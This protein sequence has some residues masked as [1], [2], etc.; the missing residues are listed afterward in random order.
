MKKSMIQMLAISALAVM[1]FVVGCSDSEMA[2]AAN[3]MKSAK[4]ALSKSV[5][6]ANKAV[7][8]TKEL[9]NLGDAI[10][11][12]SVTASMDQ[13]KQLG[14][15]TLEMVESSVELQQATQELSK[16]ASETVTQLQ[17]S[18]VGKAAKE[19]AKQIDSADLNQA[20]DGLKQSMGELNKHT[21]TLSKGVEGLKSLKSLW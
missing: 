8:V 6:A 17:N 16:K 20:V 19:L 21:E 5:D 10:Q 14:G 18:E 3:T 9:K 4:D 15:K 11:T 7:D 12:G 2:Q 13:V 1:P